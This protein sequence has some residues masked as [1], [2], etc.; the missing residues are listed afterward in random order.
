[1]YGISTLYTLSYVLVF[2]LRR[3][4]YLLEFRTLR[5]GFTNFM[6]L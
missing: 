4:S 1:M 2:F 5:N 6:G 3:P